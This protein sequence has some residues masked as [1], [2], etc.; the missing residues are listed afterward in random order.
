MSN[1]KKYIDQNLA[2]PISQLNPIDKYNQNNLFGLFRISDDNANNYKFLYNEFIQQIV[3]DISVKLHL[4]SMA[5]CETDNYV[6]F[7]HQHKYSNVNCYPMFSLE[8]TNN[9]IHFMS[10]SIDNFESHNSIDLYMP[11]LNY[12]PISLYDIGDVRFLAINTIS[13]EYGNIDIPY[14]YIEHNNLKTKTVTLKNANKNIIN[15]IK[16]GTFDG[17]VYPDGSEY[18]KMMGRYDFSDAYKKFN[19][20]NNK[21][22]I[23]CLSNFVKLNPGIQC[24]NAIAKFPGQTGIKPHTHEL[25]DYKEIES[26]N[27]SI[28]ATIIMNQAENASSQ[29]NSYNTLHKAGGRYLQATNLSIDESSLNMNL[30][31]NSSDKKFFDYVPSNPNDETYPNHY[32]IPVQVYIGNTLLNIME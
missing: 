19:G 13:A 30:N 16:N 18:Y 2:K 10:L 29:P 12:Q 5:F 20:N 32:L 26:L 27:Q 15:S 7:N 31:I 4:S 8:N 3:S 28:S 9:P 22:T 14:T 17:W 1:E 11:K 6:F 25:A 23:P 21:F 24:D